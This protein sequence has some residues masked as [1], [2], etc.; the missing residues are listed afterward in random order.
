[1]ALKTFHFVQGLSRTPLLTFPR[2]L[3]TRFSNNMLQTK[4]ISKFNNLEIQKPR[5]TN[6]CPDIRREGG[7]SGGNPQTPNYF[8]V[9]P[10]DTKLIPD[11]SRIAS[12]KC[13]VISNIFKN[14][15][16][17]DLWLT[18]ECPKVALEIPVSQPTKLIES[19]PT[20]QTQFD[21]AWISMDC[22]W[23]S[24]DKQWISMDYPWTSKDIQG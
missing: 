18:P 11:W 20:C 8:K 1:M 7:G 23:M 3:T 19:D 9:I 21:D 6:K 12:N 22:P 2:Y 14:L 17:N 4:L 24:M 16:W 10:D 13:Q 5:F 15:A